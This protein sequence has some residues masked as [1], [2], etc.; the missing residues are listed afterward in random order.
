MNLQKKKKW[1]IAYCAP[2][3]FEEM[4]DLHGLPYQVDP[5]KDI[6]GDEYTAFAPPDW[7]SQRGR[8][9]NIIT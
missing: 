2:A 1:K 9:G 5:D 3:Q 6:I 8:S 7:V 4:G